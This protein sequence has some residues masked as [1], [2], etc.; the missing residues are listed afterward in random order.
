MNARHAIRS[1][2]AA[3]DDL[4]AIMARAIVRPDPQNPR[5]G[6]IRKAIIGVALF[7][8]AITAT[9]IFAGV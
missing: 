7:L 1:A 2:E 4:D 3:L 6:T 8:A 5:K 9:A